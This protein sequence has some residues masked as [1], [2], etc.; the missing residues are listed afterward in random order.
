VL[1]HA[2]TTV[3]TAARAAGGRLIVVDAVDENAASFYRVYNFKPSPTDPRRL[4][5]K[6]STAAYALNVTWP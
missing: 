5:M 1:V 3:V 6:L 4:I 2:L